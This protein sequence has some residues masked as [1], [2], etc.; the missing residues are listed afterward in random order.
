MAQHAVLL[1]LCVIPT[2]YAAG[3]FSNVSSMA[4]ASDYI[5]D[6]IP[7]DTVAALV[8]ASA[9]AAAAE[10]DSDMAGT[11]AKLYHAASAESYP[12]PVWYTVSQMAMFWSANP[13]PLRLPLTG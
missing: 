13:P 12:L 6:L 4:F 1:L 9:A 3:F 8:I 5:M 10:A 7:C 2:G 11:A